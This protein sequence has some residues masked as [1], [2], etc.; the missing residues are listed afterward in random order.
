LP[1]LINYF[2]ILDASF[3]APPSLRSSLTVRWQLEIDKNK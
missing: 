3:R 1:K 2:A